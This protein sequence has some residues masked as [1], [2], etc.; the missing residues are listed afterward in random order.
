MLFVF[1]AGYWSY[2]SSSGWYGAFCMSFLK[3]NIGP[4]V[5]RPFRIRFCPCTFHYDSGH[6]FIRPTMRPRTAV[7]MNFTDEVNIEWK[8]NETSFSYFEFS[9]DLSSMHCI[10]LHIF[11]CLYRWT[12]DV[13]HRL[14]LGIAALVSSN[15]SLRLGVVA[16]VL[17]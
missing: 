2:W 10:R 4:L 14:A 16:P 5:H 8:W 13:E 15:T 9:N 7:I 6:N 1:S 17:S 3:L 12:F 11:L